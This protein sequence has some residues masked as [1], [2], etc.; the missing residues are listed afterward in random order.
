MSTDTP[1]APAPSVVDQVLAQIS[2]Q[3]MAFSND[4]QKE[5]EKHRK[6]MDSFIRPSKQQ[7]IQQMD[8]RLVELNRVLIANPVLID[9]VVQ[10]TTKLMDR[11]QALIS[12]ELTKALPSE[13]PP[14]P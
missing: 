2:Q 12:K 4:F 11:L 1:A 5:L 10:F 6:D 3:Q 13:T 8:L 7:L 14:V 9:T